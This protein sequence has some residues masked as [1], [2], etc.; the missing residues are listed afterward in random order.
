MRGEEERRRWVSDPSD[1]PYV[2]NHAFFKHGLLNLF[3]GIAN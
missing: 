1:L 2:E 3:G